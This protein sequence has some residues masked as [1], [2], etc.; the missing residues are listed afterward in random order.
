MDTKMISV[1][2]AII[3]TGCASVSTTNKKYSPMQYLKNYAL[4][5]CIADGFES[6]E[7]IRDAAA[8]ARGYLEFGELPLEAYTEATLLGRKFI[9][10]EYKSITGEKLILMKCIDYYNSKE[11][12]ELAK[13]YENKQ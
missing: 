6:N 4:C 10:K 9:E 12:N 5:T 7:V 3:L 11:L 1:V 2:F 13:R 8:G